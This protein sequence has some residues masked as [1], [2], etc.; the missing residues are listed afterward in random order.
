[1]N[2]LKKTNRDVLIEKDIFKPYYK[3]LTDE[4][5]IISQFNYKLVKGFKKG[6]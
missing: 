6:L 5:G 4:S 1:M 3:L 2:K